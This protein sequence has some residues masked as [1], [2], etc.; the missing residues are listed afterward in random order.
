MTQPVS[1]IRRAQTPSAGASPGLHR[2]P[3]WFA[4]APALATIVMVLLFGIAGWAQRS[5]AIA[6]RYQRDAEAALNARDFDTARVCCERL[7]QRAPN[8]PALLLGLAKSLQ[9]IGQTTDASQ[10]LER[11]APA[12]A[13]GYGPAQLFV[14]EQILYA[15][16]DS[17]SVQL[18]ET[19]ARRAL[20]A[21]P[22]SSEARSLLDRIYANTG[23]L[24]APAH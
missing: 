1:R 11:L 9:G 22:A 2:M 19:H 3:R 24:P 16:T 8:D 14:A 6:A 4:A 15:S 12:N 20:E 21:D 23:R 18:A 17:R 5:D 13:P 10:L 7:L